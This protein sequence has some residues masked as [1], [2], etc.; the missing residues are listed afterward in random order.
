MVFVRFLGERTNLGHL[1]PGPFILIWNFNYAFRPIGNITLMCVRLKESRTIRYKI[2]DKYD[3][4]NL[5]LKQT[6][7]NT[8]NI[9]QLAT[10]YER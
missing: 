5:R 1:P 3:K 7:Q 9:R 8:E 6:E 4:I 2:S 10:F